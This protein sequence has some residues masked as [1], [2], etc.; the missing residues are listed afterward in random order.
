[1]SDDDKIVH[2]FP[3]AELPENLM[4][5]AP[6]P[7]GAHYYCNHEAVRLDAHD[8]TV[9][10]ARCSAMLDPFDFLLHNAVTMTRAWEH[11]RVVQSQLAGLNERMAYLKKEE[12][13][14][15]AKVRRLAAKTNDVI[16]DRSAPV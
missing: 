9:Q 8:R 10:C 12:K 15:L 5:V 11:H 1:M 6:R 14:L 16:L 3:S 4:T 7:T 13:R 2:A